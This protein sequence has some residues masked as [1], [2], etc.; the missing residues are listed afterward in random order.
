[1]VFFFKNSISIS[2]YIEKKE[3]GFLELTFQHQ[4]RL[5]LDN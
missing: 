1:M 3:R 4:K 2:T 5:R